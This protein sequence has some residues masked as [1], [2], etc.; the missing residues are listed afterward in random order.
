ML[1]QNVKDFISAAVIFSIILLSLVLVSR[2]D[3]FENAIYLNTSDLSFT[4]FD[5]KISLDSR[6]PD[7]LS[8]LRSF[9]TR[10]LGQNFIL[11][12]ENIIG[13]FIDYFTDALVLLYK[14]CCAVT[15]VSG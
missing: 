3:F 7:F 2:Q 8:H 15:G 5:I 9:Y 14:L 13:F 12:C 6:V 1:K 4:F 10:I 11:C